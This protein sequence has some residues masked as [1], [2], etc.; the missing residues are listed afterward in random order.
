MKVIIGGRQSGKTTSLVKWLLE[1]VENR[2][3]CVANEHQVRMVCERFGLSHHEVVTPE[4][5]RGHNKSIGID[6]WNE[7]FQNNTFADDTITYYKVHAY[8][9]N[10]DQLDQATVYNVP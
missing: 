2:V 1:D 6:D 5:L 9:L 8:T 4:K 7:H 3:I 10:I